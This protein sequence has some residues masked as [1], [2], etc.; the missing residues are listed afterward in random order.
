[1]ICC[2]NFTKGEA[3]KEIRKGI[4]LDN[5]VFYVKLIYTTSRNQYFLFFLS[6]SWGCKNIIA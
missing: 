5:F 3:V 4:G 6:D 2:L 1:M